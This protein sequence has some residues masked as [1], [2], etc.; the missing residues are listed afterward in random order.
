VSAGTTAV[1][2]C[3]WWPP[4]PPVEGDFLRTDS[5]SCYRIDEIRGSDYDHI[6]YVFTVTRL[7][8]NAVEPGAP[9][10]HPWRFRRVSVRPR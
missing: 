5:G 4:E 7:G 3:Y 1:F 2:R 8:K 9:G 10:V 6:A